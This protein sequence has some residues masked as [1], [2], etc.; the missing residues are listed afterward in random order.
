M[1]FCTIKTI[2]EPKAFVLLKTNSFEKLK[3]GGFKIFDF[4][5]M[6]F[7]KNLKEILNKS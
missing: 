1:K 7:I 5:L 3:C 6:L 4:R 2:I